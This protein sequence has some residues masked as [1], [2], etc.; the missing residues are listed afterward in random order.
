MGVAASKTFIEPQ[1][2]VVSSEY[3]KKM[4]ILLQQA[5]KRK[6]EE[7]HMWSSFVPAI[8]YLIFLWLVPFDNTRSLGD[9]P[10]PK[11]S[12]RTFMLSISSPHHSQEELDRLKLVTCTVLRGRDHALFL[13]L[14]KFGWMDTLWSL[15]L[16]KY[17]IKTNTWRHEEMQLSNATSSILLI[18]I[19]Y[20]HVCTLKEK[21]GPMQL[22]PVKFS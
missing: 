1:S 10:S 13:S 22:V 7:R 6:K 21:S 14:W 17:P 2:A 16:A 9:P 11:D 12:S 20:Y 5:K 8:Y 3:N 19:F 15:L 4:R 18:N